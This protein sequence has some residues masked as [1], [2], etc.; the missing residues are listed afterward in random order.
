MFVLRSTYQKQLDRN[1]ELIDDRDSLRR[2][3]ADA[4]HGSNDQASFVIDFWRLNPFS[5]ERNVM[6]GRPCTIFGYFDN[7]GKVAE[8]VWFCS[9]DTHNK[10]VKEY[11]E[12]KAKK[13]S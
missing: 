13:E 10:V 5:V 3:L 4:Q 1:A 8:W 11:N 9:V 6:D 7:E 12:Y 2:K